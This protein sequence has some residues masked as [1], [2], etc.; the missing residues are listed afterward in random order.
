MN[1]WELGNEPDVDPDLLT[2]DFEE[3][4]GCWGNN[5]DPY[6]GGRYY[7]EMLKVGYP[8]I[9]AADS[10]AKILIGGLLLD[11]DPDDPNCTN[12]KPA[13]FFEGILL[14][15]GGNF[16]DIVS[17]HGY[18][19]YWNGVVRDE[20]AE[21]WDEI[22]GVVVGKAKF[23]QQVMAKYNVDKP[24][25]LTEGAALCPEWNTTDCNPP[26]ALFQNAKADY[27]TWLS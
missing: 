27:V 12:P 22:G 19:H 2:P 18:S 9:K 21:T 24:L 20:V 1:Y 16:F 5:D 25:F 7:A 8:T 6:Y 26:G 17:F 23:L 10:D 11:C 15:G 14:N 4:F 3:H 13:R